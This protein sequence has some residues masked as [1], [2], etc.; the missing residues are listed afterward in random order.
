M[1]HRVGA[2]VL[3]SWRPW[4]GSTEHPG[5]LLRIGQQEYL[6]RGVGRPSSS[7]ELG[8]GGGERDGVP[9]TL[10]DVADGSPRRRG[11]RGEAALDGRHGVVLKVQK[12][13][14]ANT[15][16]LTRAWTSRSTSSPTLPP[17]V[18][19]L[20]QG[21]PSGRLHPGRPRQRHHRP[22]RRRDPGGDRAGPV[23]D[24]L[25]HH[26]DLAPVALPLSLLAGLLVLTPPARRS[27]P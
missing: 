14:Q 9:I 11:R 4:M 17:G 26:A 8:H 2:T 15:L 13:P 6:I 10:A 27:T 24:E 20:S 19:A 5:R 7:L 18:S 1:E 12:Q 22:A 21:L 23:P 3:R 16:E 25:A